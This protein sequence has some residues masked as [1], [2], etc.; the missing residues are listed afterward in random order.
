MGR[1]AAP[2]PERRG[3]QAVHLENYNYIT[4]AYERTAELLEPFQVAKGS[5]FETLS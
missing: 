1:A 3:G 4:I 5:G 2:G